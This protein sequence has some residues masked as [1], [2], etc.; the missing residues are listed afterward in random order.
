MIS[1]TPAPSAVATAEPATA[2]AAACLLCGGTRTRWVHSGGD[3]RFAL[4]GEFHVVRCI[5]CGFTWTAQ[6]DGFE[7]SDWYERGYWRH[8]QPAAKQRG[9]LSRA[10]RE[11]WRVLDGAPRPS[12]WAG[13]GRVLDLG[14][15]T[16]YDTL[17]LQERSLCAVGM[18][19][20]AKGLRSAQSAGAS[21]VRATTDAL[22][23]ARHSFDC[24]VMS[25]CLEHLPQPDVA[26]R[27]ALEAL[28]PGGK[29]V[30]L[31]PNV[32]S[33]L[34]PIFGRRW[35]HWHLPYHLWHFDARS[36]TTLV[37]RAG[38]TRLR[39]RTVTPGDW[40]LLNAGLFRERTGCGQVAAAR[41]VR[42]A[43]AP[44]MRAVDALGAGD[45]LVLEAYAP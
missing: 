35:A 18:D 5:R 16:G 17:E 1:A 39:V 33:V 38:F 20:S 42:L 44:L 45:C 34:R 4:G 22:P 37:R 25:Q 14:C 11:A 29:L 30:V 10:L 26:L 40:L 27:D 23:V 19:T 41:A 9:G 43:V 21:V 13:G 36:M 15:G 32:R 2:A 31:A 24:V 8:E 28:R 3:D 12:R 7:L 6:P